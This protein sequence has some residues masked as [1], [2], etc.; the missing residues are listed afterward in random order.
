MFFN[1]FVSRPNDSRIFVF[2]PSEILTL[3]FRVDESI[4]FEKKSKN[5]EFVLSGKIAAMNKRP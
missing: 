2:F 5:G 3:S 1:R 4:Y